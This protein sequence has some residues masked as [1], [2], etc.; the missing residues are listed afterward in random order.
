MW[1]E[2]AD[3]TPKLPEDVPAFVPLWHLW[4][5][6][7]VDHTK[8]NQQKE[9]IWAGECLTKQSFIQQGIEKYIDVWKSMMERDAM[10][11]KDMAGYVQYWERIHSEIMDPA[12]LTL[13]LLQDGFGRQPICSGTI[14]VAC[15]RGLGMIFLPTP[16]L[17]MILWSLTHIVILQKYGQ[18]PTLIPIKMISLETLCYTDPVIDIASLCGLVEEY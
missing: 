8:M 14:R 3:G 7:V 17:R 13:T 16:L 9:L 15:S 6:I 12:P 4:E 18:S 11:A 2:K 10:Y 1:S 5:N